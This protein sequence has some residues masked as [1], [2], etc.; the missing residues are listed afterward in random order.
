MDGLGFLSAT[1]LI[2]MLPHRDHGLW[3]D[4]PV[5]LRS[6]PRVVTCGACDRTLM[7]K[8][9]FLIRD[10]EALNS[11]T[12]TLGAS[13]VWREVL[14]PAPTRWH[15]SRTTKYALACLVEMGVVA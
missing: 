6:P 4:T 13:A 10:W 5:V 11:G 2:P 12:M 1:S 15:L 8:Y 7:E 9:Q 3:G 14:A